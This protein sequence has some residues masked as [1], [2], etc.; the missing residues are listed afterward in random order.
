MQSHFIVKPNLVLSLG[1]SLDNFCAKIINFMF[2]MFKKYLIRRCIKFQKNMSKAAFH[3]KA[4]DLDSPP[5]LPQHVL[6]HRARGIEDTEP[7][8]T[9][10]DIVEAADTPEQ[11]KKADEE[12]MGDSGDS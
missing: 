8:N 1:W 3:Q 5:T 4:L 10:T 7:D 6:V 9:E 11:D 12:K 2:R